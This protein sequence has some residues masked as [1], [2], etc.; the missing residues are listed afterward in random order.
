M[1]KTISLMFVFTLL[2]APTALACNTGPTGEDLSTCNGSSY[3]QH[4]T[5][6]MLA[7]GGLLGEGVAYA[8]APQV[9]VVPVPSVVIKAAVDSAKGSTARHVAL[10]GV[11][12]VV[13]KFLLDLAM[14][15]KDPTDKAKKWLPWVCSGLGVLIGFVTYLAAGSSW[16]DA[17]IL[18]AG[19]PAA[20]L[21]NEL[22]NA[23]RTKLSKPVTVTIT[24]G[25]NA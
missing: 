8:Q 21:V 16:I 20:V 15:I 5:F 13:L 11:L 6:S 2:L 18:G 12:A 1:H 19:A 7:I 9:K 4:I 24:G 14:S 22:A 25:N 17:A 3:S 23:L 10:A